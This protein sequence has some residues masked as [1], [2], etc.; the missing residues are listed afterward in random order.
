MPAEASR[1]DVKRA[2]KYARIYDRMPRKDAL[3]G[4]SGRGVRDVLQLSETGMTAYSESTL[5]DRALVNAPMN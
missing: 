4:R 1:R 5:D 2:Q 3:L